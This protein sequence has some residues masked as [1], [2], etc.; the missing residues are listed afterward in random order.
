MNET[1]NELQAKINETKGLIKRAT[2]A[3]A[4]MKAINKYFRKK[5]TCRGFLG[6]TEE[7]AIALNAQVSRSSN[8]P[9]NSKEL[10]DSNNDLRQLKERLMSLQDQLAE[11]QP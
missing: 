1:K 5:G 8:A 11:V 6:I 10:E 2:E 4:F 9:F 7:K 3:H